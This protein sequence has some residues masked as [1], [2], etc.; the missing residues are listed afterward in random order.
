MSIWAY[1]FFFYYTMSCIKK[2]IPALLKHWFYLLFDEW[3]K[4]I[5]DQLQ[6]DST[7]D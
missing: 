3:G 1:I 6:S 4:D 5:L 2:I 7:E